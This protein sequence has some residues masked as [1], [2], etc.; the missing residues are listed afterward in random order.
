[1]IMTNLMNKIISIKSALVHR[2]RYICGFSL[3]YRPA[4]EQYPD[5]ASA[6]SAT[7]LYPKTKGFL[8][9]DLSVCTGCGECIKI[10]PVGAISMKSNISKDGRV[11][12]EDFRIQLGK[13]F[14]CS[15]CVD[16]CPVNSLR[17]TKEYE[18]AADKFE[19]MNLIFS[20]QD[21]AVGMNTVHK[22]QKKIRTYEV[23][24]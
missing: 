21:P 19:D 8:A 9:N 17:H 3:Q 11:N 5:M 15:I 7:D 13:C 1:M 18:M 10:C 4:A 6:R 2:L 22:N 20:S 24:R 14:S 23:R 16:L 12:V